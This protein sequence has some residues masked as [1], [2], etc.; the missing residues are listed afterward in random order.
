[1]R[2][3]TQGHHRCIRSNSSKIPWTQSYQARELYAEGKSGSGVGSLVSEPAITHQDKP[4]SAS[5]TL[6]SMQLRTR[7]RMV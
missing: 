6:R 7:K 4:G 5:N 1:M 2:R 3:R